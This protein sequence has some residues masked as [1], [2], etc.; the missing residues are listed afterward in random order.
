LAER[1]GIKEEDSAL[2]N[3]IKHFV[4]V[5]SS[6]TDKSKAKNEILD[7][8]DE[9]IKANEA[10]KD[11][12][13]NSTIK[14]ARNPSSKKSSVAHVAEFTEKEDNENKNGKFNSAHFFKK[15][16]ISIFSDSNSI[17]VLLDY[18]QHLLEHHYLH[19]HLD[20]VWFRQA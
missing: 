20:D 17:L 11:S 8:I 5:S 14:S 15:A 13:N 3:F 16:N 7:N 10:A 6:S 9:D 12:E 2:N 4:V 18:H 1:V 19:C